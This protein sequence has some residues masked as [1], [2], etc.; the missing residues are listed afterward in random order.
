MNQPEHDSHLTGF[1]G[2]LAPVLTVAFGVCAAMLVTAYVLHFPGL[3]LAGGVVGLAMLAVGGVAFVVLLGPAGRAKVIRCG[4]LAGLLAGLVSLLAMGSVLTAQEDGGERP[5]LALMI[6]GWLVFMTALGV[7][8]GLVTKRS[9]RPDPRPSAWWLPVLGAITGVSTL[10]L[11]TAGGVVTAAE[12]GLAV[13]DWPATFGANMFLYPLSKMTGGVY[14]EHAHRLM[15]A[16]VGLSTFA[17]MVMSL[18][19][20]RGKL[21]KVLA[22]VAFVLV[23]AQGLAGGLRVTEEAVVLAM[24]HGVV[25]QLFLAL[26]ATIT[27]TSTRWWREAEHTKTSLQLP[28][29]ALVIL[30]VQIIFGAVAR[31]FPDSLH[32]VMTHAGF[33]LFAAGAIVAA[34]ARASKNADPLVK[35]LGKSSV[36]TVG[37]QMVLGVAALGVVMMTRDAETPHAMD[38]VLT[39]AHQVVGALLLSIMVLLVVASARVAKR[40]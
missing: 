14:Y 35:R 26:I 28:I 39:T 8:M 21:I 18:L 13:P 9:A 30:F 11:L 16:F 17:L 6:G 19:G 10:A 4:A 7:V 36:H 3:N 24:L 27:L 22:V 38:L 20:G 5:S 29:A 23:C 32:G 12:A 34:G 33:S 31:H 37:L 40:G 25:G 15:G 1:R 2:L